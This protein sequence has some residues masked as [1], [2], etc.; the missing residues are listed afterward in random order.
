MKI[1]VLPDDLVNLIAAGEVIENPASVV[2]E[3]VENSIDAGSKRIRVEIKGGGQQYIK[4]DDDGCGIPKEEMVDA[5]K[6]HATSKIKNF[7]DLQQVMTLGFRGEALSSIGAVSHMRILSAEENKS[8]GLL[9]VDAGQIGSFETAARSQGTM[10][11]VRSLFYNVPVR[12]KFQKIETLCASDI[13]NVMHNFAL[14]YPEIAF[15]Y[16]SQEREI[17]SVPP[18]NEKEPIEALRVRISDIFGGF[19]IKEMTQIALQD[20][21]MNIYGFVGLPQNY[22]KTKSGQYLLLNKR[23]VHIGF[24]SQAVKDG[25]ATTMEEKGQPIFILHVNMPSSFLDVNVNPQKTFVRIKDI[26]YVK[27]MVKKAVSNS[28]YNGF[29]FTPTFT[30]EES[31]S[32][33]EEIILPSFDATMKQE[34]LFSFRLEQEELLEE[35]KPIKQFSHYLL[36]D[37]GCSKRFQ[38]GILI[39]DLKAAYCR[40]VFDSFSD[41][42]SGS[43]QKLLAPILLDILLDDM[44]L[45]E[46]N[47]NRLEEMGFEFRI[48]GKMTVAIDGISEFIHQNDIRDLFLLAL[49]EEINDMGREKKRAREI[50]RVIKAKRKIFSQEEANKIAKIFLQEGKN[51]F[52]PLGNSVFLQLKEKDFME[53]FLTKGGRFEKD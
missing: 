42:S 41:I 13:L 34:E 3:L 49:H 9:Q 27:D 23:S 40:L 17:F 37:G 39:L 16:V 8:G 1:Q 29:S 45:L 32:R 46:N 26:K 44:A 31:I 15:S 10:I 4:V 22:R 36:L 7:D 6:S 25:Y 33:V 14:A 52:D 35:V 11:E 2:K 18:I 20:G 19:F 51:M 53:L 5:V 21:P 47:A 28:L 48:V 12:K 24:I 43:R 50:C 30:R 38:D